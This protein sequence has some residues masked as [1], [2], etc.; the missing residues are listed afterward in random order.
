MRTVRSVRRS[1]APTRC[2]PIAR[3][4]ASRW[5]RTRS[6]FPA[7]TRFRSAPVAPSSNTPTTTS[8]WTNAR[9]LVAPRPVKSAMS[10]PSSLA[11]A[12]L[13]HRRP[14]VLWLETLRPHTVSS[15]VDIH[16]GREGREP[17]SNA[18]KIQ[19]TAAR[20][21]DPMF[22]TEIWGYDLRHGITSVAMGPGRGCK[23]PRGTHSSVAQRPPPS[24]P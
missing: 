3:C 19:H 12:A 4:R 17:E 8:C 6:D 5:I 1:T 2:G 22:V 14:T 23:Q 20:P 9:D 18:A 11:M 10:L 16:A 24:D 15:V 7:A 21:S 13:A